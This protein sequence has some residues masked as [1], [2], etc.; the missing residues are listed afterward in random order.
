MEFAMVLPILTL[1][2][3]GI[4]EWGWYF[5]RELSTVNVARHAVRVGATTRPAF[6]EAPGQCTE[7]VSAAQ[8]TASHLFEQDGITPPSDAVHVSIVS[9]EHTCG[10]QLQIDLPYAPIAGMIP[11]PGANKIAITQPLEFVNGC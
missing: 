2:L 6:G 1:L 10:L 9:V 8:A 4:M 7:C 11:V 3:M 5:Y